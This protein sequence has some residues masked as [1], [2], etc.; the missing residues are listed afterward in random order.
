MPTAEA[1]FLVRKEGLEPS[2][3]Y[4]PDPKSGASANSATFAR[5][6]ISILRRAVLKRR[7]RAEQCTNRRRGVDFLAPRLLEI[8]H[9]GRG[10]QLSHAPQQQLRSR[11]SREC[12]SIN[13]RTSSLEK[14]R[15][16]SARS[17]VDDYQRRRCILI[18]CA[19][20]FH[21]GVRFPFANSLA[22]RLCWASSVLICNRA[23]V[24]PSHGNWRAELIAMPARSALRIAI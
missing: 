1:D 17:K 14:L 12:S 24:C 4:P 3:F 21:T 10:C 15:M 20:G 23:L 13:S 8:A 19:S 22:R 2:R 6:S 7:P 9:K 5:R 11:R 16:F 18:A